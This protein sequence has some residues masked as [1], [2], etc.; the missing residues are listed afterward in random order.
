MP[1]WRRP[2][3]CRRR[4]SASAVTM[5]HSSLTASSD[6]GASGWMA[7][8]LRTRATHMLRQ[9]LGE[10]FGD[11]ED[12]GGAAPGADAAADLHQATGVVGHDGVGAGL[13]GVA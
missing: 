12:A 9:A 4:K 10:E 13:F 1:E 8:L 11:V 5:T 2:R 3:W 7:S 6:N